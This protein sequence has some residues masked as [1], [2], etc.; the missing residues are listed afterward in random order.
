M[1]HGCGKPTNNGPNTAERLKSHG[2]ANKQPFR[3]RVNLSLTISR[4]RNP[5]N[6]PYLQIHEHP[7]N[8]VSL[9]LLG[10]WMVR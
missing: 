9:I 10:F 1:E 4:A 7:G 2:V 3:R 6:L 5:N 8:G